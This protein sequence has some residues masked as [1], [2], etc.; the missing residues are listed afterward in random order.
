ML[1]E[2]LTGLFIGRKKK[3]T[4]I[5]RLKS[6]IRK[7]VEECHSE[8]AAGNPEAK[9]QLD[10]LEKTITEQSLRLLRANAKSKS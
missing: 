7:T 1:L 8:A 3:D 9:K 5:R 4:E 6:E 10:E 2:W